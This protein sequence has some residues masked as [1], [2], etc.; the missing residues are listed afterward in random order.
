[1]TRGMAVPFSNGLSD[2]SKS[3]V[4][5]GIKTRQIEDRSNFPDFYLEEAIK[6]S[7]SEKL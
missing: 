6:E 2:V 7:N 4:I 3:P 1:M 5:A